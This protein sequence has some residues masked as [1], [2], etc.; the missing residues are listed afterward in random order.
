MN[1]PNLLTI[2]RILLIPVFV[3]LILR[4][5]TLEAL[6]VFA[7]ASITDGLDGYIARVYHLKTR[8]G[9]F[10]DPLADKLLL[11]TAYILLAVMDRLPLW[12]TEVVVV[13]DT[14]ILSG[15]L[16]LYLSNRKIDLSPSILGKITTFV[17]LATILLV[18]LS[19]Y[20]PV[21]LQVLFPLYL[22]NLLVTLSSCGH[23]FYLGF[24]MTASARVP[25]KG[26][27]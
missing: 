20:S 4:Q 26:E 5:K 25:M 15:I 10:L 13:R 7:A 1:L 18:L 21:I 17:Q 3:Y 8:L 6:F 14:V 19:D 9:A 23:Y 12:L 16:Y 2:I 22:L 11:L 24:K 27:E